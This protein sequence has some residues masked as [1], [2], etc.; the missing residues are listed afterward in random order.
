MSDNKKE[1]HAVFQVL[2]FISNPPPT[3]KLSSD[4]QILLV[5]LAKHKGSKGIYPSIPT[6]AREL[7]RD[8]RCIRRTIKRLKD[9]KII[10][11]DKNIGKNNHYK[12]S[13][14]QGVD[15]LT[16]T[17]N[18]QG[19]DALTPRAYTPETQG[20]DAL[21]SVKRSNKKQER[22]I[23]L[24]IFEPDEANIL[25]AKDLSV[26]LYENLN[27]FRE[28]HKGNKTQYEFG[29]WLKKNK[30]YLES[31]KNKQK[32]Q[33]AEAYSAVN[34]MPFYESPRKAEL[35]KRDLTMEPVKIEKMLPFREQLKIYKQQQGSLPNGK[36]HGTDP[37]GNKSG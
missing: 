34:H 21:Q 5:F 19:V 28:R 32:V 11:I 3:I 6:L 8:E 13:T 2:N 31:K 33:A 24:S 14:S 9:K 4:E 37:T 27:S 17:H 12:L 30:E 15:A 35:I 26:D 23:S 22:E 7:T 18:T 1:I 10:I 16:I 36:D 20:V 25:L 29:R